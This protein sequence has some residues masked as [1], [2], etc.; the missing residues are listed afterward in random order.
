[1]KIESI[2]KLTNLKVI[3]F[4]KIKR[5]NF[6]RA[7]CIGRIV[8]CKNLAEAHRIRSPPVYGLQRNRR[9]PPFRPCCSPDSIFAYIPA[10]RKR[11]NT[12]R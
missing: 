5:P 3:F 6:L 2:Y 11:R 4:C 8:A 7:V 10:R 9:S 12:D 1:M